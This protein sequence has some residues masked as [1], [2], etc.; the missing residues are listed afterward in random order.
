M[1]INHFFYR[2]MQ[3][4]IYYCIKYK[5]AVMPKIT[6]TPKNIPISFRMTQ[7][8]KDLIDSYCKAMKISLSDFFLN[9]AIEKIV[10]EQLS[11]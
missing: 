1:K 6:E 3:K 10:K 8:Q 9:T 11:K 2:L 7:I 5:N 4:D